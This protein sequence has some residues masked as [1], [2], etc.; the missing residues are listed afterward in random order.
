[1]IYRGSVVKVDSKSLVVMT[2]DCTFERVKKFEGIQEGMEIYFEKDDIIK[3]KKSS[4]RSISSIAAAI[5]L[6]VI[7]SVYGMSFWN[8]NYQAMALVSVDINPSVEIKVNKKRN[9]I[10]V[11]AINED[12]LNLPLEDLKDKYL[13]DALE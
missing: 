6:A 9:V 1:M 4:I 12:A 7:T 3:N 13:T 8:I 5:L 2:E 11:T 10:N